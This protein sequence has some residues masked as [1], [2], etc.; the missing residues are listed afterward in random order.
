[1][2]SPTPTAAGGGGGPTGGG[3]SNEGG[4]S[5]RHSTSER[6]SVSESAAVNGP[7]PVE[8]KS[9]AGSSS[10]VQ[11]LEISTLALAAWLAEVTELAFGI[12]EG[13]NDC[14]APDFPPD[15]ICSSNGCGSNLRRQESSVRNHAQPS[16]EDSVSLVHFVR[17]TYSSWLGCKSEI[18]LSQLICDCL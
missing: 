13:R 6:R 15:V 2:K 11:A 3:G 14:T 17:L 7:A 1:M 8:P 18:S 10:A 9:T 16:R 12:P 4:V 5:F